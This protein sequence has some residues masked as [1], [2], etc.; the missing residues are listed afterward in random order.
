MPAPTSG[1]VNTSGYQ[2]TPQSYI[3]KNPKSAILG[4]TTNE[5]RQENDN[6]RKLVE[7]LHSKGMSTY[8]L[9]DPKQYFKLFQ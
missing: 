3:S 4:A 9:S 8:D 1:S 6:A 5:L 7:E 2:P